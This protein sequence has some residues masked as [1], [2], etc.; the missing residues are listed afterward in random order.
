MQGGGDSEVRSPTSC[1]ASRT[2]RATHAAR[3][4]YEQ[5]WGVTIQPKYGWHLTQMFEAMERGDLKALYVVGENPA[6]SEADAV[7]TM[8][9]HRIA[10]PHRRP[11]HLPD[12]HRAEIA[13]VVLP[14]SASWCEAEG[15]VTNSERRV[16]RVRR[17]LIRPGRHAMTSR[18]S[19]R[20]PRGSAPTGATRPRRRSGT[21]SARCRRCTRAWRTAG[22]TKP[23]CSGRAGTR[24]IP[25]SNSSTHAS[26]T[27]RSPA[28]G[29]P[30]VVVVHELPVDELSD[31]FPIR[32]TTGR[33]LGLVQHR[34]AERG[35]LLAGLRRGE[36]LDLSPEDCEQPRRRPG[37]ARFS[38]HRAAAPWSRQSAS[39][40]H[41]GPASRS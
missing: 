21:S 4:R 18:S 34:G 20:S 24:S 17:A 8:R 36:S 26:G 29:H 33:R 12:P 15:T 25:A 16:Q 14:A 38:S 2:S 37:R 7:H 6:Q 27:S 40:T 10:R 3:A 23:V 19:A 1:R 13:D 41:C 9:R 5:A 22:S 39:T 32:L 30:S 31:E 35:L 28:H 11:G